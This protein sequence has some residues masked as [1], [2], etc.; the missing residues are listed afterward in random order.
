MVLNFPFLSLSFISNCDKVSFAFLKGFSI[1]FFWHS[2][3]AAL[4][5]LGQF[6]L[7]QKNLDEAQR[8]YEVK[9]CINEVKWTPIKK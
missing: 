8:C 7:V 3:G 5:N 1:N 2:V 6:Y 9:L 4:H